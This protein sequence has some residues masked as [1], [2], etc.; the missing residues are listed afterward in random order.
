M[1]DGRCDTHNK[2]IGPY[3]LLV[4]EQAHQL[5]D[6]RGLG[7]DTIQAT[8]EL[9]DWVLS[10]QYA[11]SSLYSPMIGGEL[12]YSIITHLRD[13]SDGT[14]STP[15]FMYSAHD[16]TLTAL[17]S[18]LQE[19]V[20]GTPPYASFIAFRLRGGDGTPWAVKMHYNSWEQAYPMRLCGEDLSEDGWCPLTVWVENALPWALEDAHSA[21]A[22]VVWTPKQAWM[23]GLMGSF[24]IL[25][26][27]IG[28]A[29]LYS[30]PRV[31]APSPSLSPT[32]SVPHEEEQGEEM[33][34][35]ERS[36]PSP[37]PSVAPPPP[38][39]DSVEIHLDDSPEGEK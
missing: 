29:F 30:R 9:A 39:N 36:P 27:L 4:C 25:W 6:W 17:F 5:P 22:I 34:P 21:C 11:P 19:D 12:L 23:I 10:R 18:A 35:M 20:T 37:S 38:D 1:V 28:I 31:T 13:Y 7:S 8:I 14:T 33:Q 2:I 26:T 16:T 32:P 3:D 15:L 24:L